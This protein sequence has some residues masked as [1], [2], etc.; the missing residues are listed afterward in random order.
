MT[1]DEGVELF[2]GLFVG[3][4]V[5]MAIPVEALGVIAQEKWDQ[6]TANAFLEA[7]APEVCP[8]GKDRCMTRWI[9]AVHGVT[10]YVKHTHVVRAAPASKAVH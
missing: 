9:N 7:F 3:M 5:G 8:C 6:P 1:K 4:P 2:R 10:D